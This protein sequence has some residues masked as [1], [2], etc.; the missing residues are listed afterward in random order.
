VSLPNPVPASALAYEATRAFL[1]AVLPAGTEVIRGQVNRVPEPVSPNFVLMS[2]ATRLRLSTNQD[3][4]EDVSFVAS[5]AGTVMTVTEVLLGALAAGQPLLGTGVTTGST[6]VAQLTG[7][8]GG[9]GTYTVSP[10][11]TVASGKL[12]SGGKQLVQHT[13]LGLQLD[14]H[15]PASEDNAQI[16]S[17]TLRDEWG[18]R[19]WAEVSPS[20]EVVPLLAD[21]PQY[22][23]FVN[24]EDQWEYR[25]V[26]TARLQVNTSIRAPQEFADEL[27]PTLIDVE[28]QFPA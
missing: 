3:T 14:V 15:G 20:P 1:L 21:D 22:L 23:P 24:G 6:V 5:V 8:P 19:R 10:G 25:W 2:P 26:V 12:A 9:V 17:T 28:A 4:Y 7:T 18:L 11:Q 16:I 27:H 13:E